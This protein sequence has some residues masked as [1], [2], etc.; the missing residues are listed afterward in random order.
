M[1]HMRQPGRKISNYYQDKADQKTNK[2]IGK[3][4][5]V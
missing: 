1:R 5:K 2:D 3:W 4:D